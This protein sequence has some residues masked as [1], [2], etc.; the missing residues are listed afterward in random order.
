MSKLIQHVPSWMTSGFFHYMQEWAP[1]KDDATVSSVALDMEYMGNRSGLRE[2]SP[3][4]EKLTWF[5]DNVILSDEEMVQL[6]DIMK[7]MFVNDWAR[8]WTALQEEYNPIENYNRIE[9]HTP[10]VTTTTKTGTDVTSQ[11]DTKSK[12]TSTSE[13]GVKPLATDGQEYEMLTKSTSEG[14][15]LEDEN[16]TT[17]RTTGDKDKN[18]TET[19]HSGTDR[20]ETR[21]NIGVTTSQQMLESE[22]ALR[23]K[24]YFDSVMDDMDTVLTIPFWTLC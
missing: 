2:A 4:V 5:R 20:S 24:H 18:V 15:A 1:W 16:A 13:S 21:G 7:S 23:K 14:E 19:S 22:Y 12:T 9:T 10:G 3:L 17:T 11:S 6:T 8:L